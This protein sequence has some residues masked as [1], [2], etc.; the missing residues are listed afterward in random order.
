MYAEKIEATTVFEKASQEHEKTN[1]DL[2]KQLEE[3]RK[4]KLEMQ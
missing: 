3:E 4:R 2:E 1:D